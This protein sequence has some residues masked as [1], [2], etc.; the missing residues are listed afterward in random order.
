MYISR[1]NIRTALRQIL[2][3]IG[4][5]EV[6][7]PE[8]ESQCIEIL[9]ARRKIPFIVDWEQGDYRLNKLLGV[10]QEPTSTNLREIYL[11]ASE[12]DAKI[13]IIATEY[14]VS[15]VHIGDLSRNSVVTDLRYIA[16][17]ISS[18]TPIQACLTQVAGLR[19]YGNHLE[20][21]EALKTALDLDP[22][23][24]RL[25]LELAQTLIQ[26]QVWDE[27][28][29]LATS[30]LSRSPN[31][32]RTLHISGRCLMKAGRFNEAI[33]AFEQAAAINPLNVERLIGFGNA[34]LQTGKIQEA[35]EKFDTALTID[36]T[37]KGAKEGKGQCQLMAGEVNE[38]LTL[39]NDVMTGKELAAVFNA[40]AIL[41]IRQLRFDDGINLYKS[42]L[43]ALGK[44]VKIAARLLFNMGLA[45]YKDGK[46][47]QAI[48]AF[49]KAVE[50]DPMFEAAATNARVLSTL[51]GQ[52]E[53]K[54]VPVDK[55]PA[56]SEPKAKAPKPKEQ[57]FV[58]D[59]DGDLSNWQ[60][61]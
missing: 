34:L 21:A 4:T 27:A 13:V 54:K 57:S 48:E 56:V 52:S 44:D 47:V 26:M 35:M 39:L 55:K 3:E 50:A 15:R 38:A 7:V 6:L 41:S 32:L 11:L 14:N 43:G 36:D 59:F 61:I 5:K 28:Q 23:N 17:R 37:H 33:E 51:S 49:Q 31:N 22:N 29:R 10:A 58:D 24:P 60:K 30:V 42:A 19:Y 20:A 2:K 40:A 9:M 1:P 53:S 25:A 8:S 45:F 12:M 16:E 18:L 46:Q